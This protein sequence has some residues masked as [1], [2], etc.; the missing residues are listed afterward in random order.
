MNHEN[1]NAARFQFFPLENT[2]NHFEN[3]LHCESF[4]LTILL[5]GIGLGLLDLDSLALTMPD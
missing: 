3:Q 1:C 5:F 2:W 4:A